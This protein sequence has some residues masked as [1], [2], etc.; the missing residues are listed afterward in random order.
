MSSTL[1]WLVARGPLVWWAVAVVCVVAGAALGPRLAQA[2]AMQRARR[3]LGALGPS[4]D[5]V[6]AGESI[7]TVLTGVLRVDDEKAP[8]AAL[9]VTVAPEVDGGDATVQSDAA[10]G[11]VLV[12]GAA[13]VRLDGGLTITLGS[14]P[15]K[16]AVDLARI[17]GDDVGRVRSVAALH[18]GDRV[19]VAGVIE[20]LHEVD[21]RA[22]Y[23]GAAPAWKLTPGVAGRVLLAFEGPATTSLPRAVLFATG[24]LFVLT[25]WAMVSSVAGASLLHSTER[26]RGTV[27]SNNTRSVCRGEGLGG[28]AVASTVPWFRA[29]ALESLAVSLA[30]AERRTRDT[31]AAL[32]VV[33]RAAETPCLARAALFEEVTDYERAAKAWARCGTPEAWTRAARVSFALGRFREASEALSHTAINP[34]ERDGEPANQAL[35]THLL[36]GELRRAAAVAA[37]LAEV[38]LQQPARRRQATQLLCVEASLLARAGDPSA[39]AR[40]QGFVEGEG[41]VGAHGPCASLASWMQGAASREAVTRNGFLNLRNNYRWHFDDLSRRALD[42][43]TVRTQFEWA[44]R[45]EPVVGDVLWLVLDQARFDLDT[46]AW[47]DAVGLIGRARTAFSPI[48]W[49]TSETPGELATAVQEVEES[50]AFRRRGT[51][52]CGDLIEQAPDGEG[53]HTYGGSPWKRECVV[54]TLL[55]RGRPLG[56]RDWELIGVF[57][58]PLLQDAITRG[59]ATA[60]LARL[61]AWRPDDGDLPRRSL[62]YAASARPAVAPRLG[63]WLTTE[64]R[65]VDDAHERIMETLSDRLHVAHAL[66]DRALTDETR[67]ILARHRAALLD[68]D[69][70]MVL[71]LTRR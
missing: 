68:E 9:S 11:L 40:L 26:A 50:V 70:A 35:Y 65:W 69:N 33:H 30:C 8:W 6:P 19:R 21:A 2:L 37:G 20:S 24:A 14:R 38:R 12:V 58:Y 43:A 48:V 25:Q 28:A 22:G 67:T 63:A 60:L 3:I 55:S 61:R 7:A 53:D 4:R 23:R 47:D 56:E 10:Q 66:G 45:A 39:A 36:A 71:A 41:G 31:W 15:A 62:M 52:T 64:D 49:S 18:A 13:R 29:K 1:L 59:D 16:G 51:A 57:S 54:R 42:A 46:G 44:R 27:T 34:H 32:E 5:E 17:A